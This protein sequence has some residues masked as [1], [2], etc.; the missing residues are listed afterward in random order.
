MLVLLSIFVTTSHA[1]A[2]TFK[3]IKLNPSSRWNSPTSEVLSRKWGPP[4][5]PR[6]FGSRIV[7]MHEAGSHSRR[8]YP[9]RIP[10]LFRPYSFDTVHHSK[11]VLHLLDFN[12]TS[13]CTDETSWW[14][15]TPIF[16]NGGDTLQRPH[17][18]H[19]PLLAGPLL[20]SL[21]RHHRRSKNSMYRHWVLPAPRAWHLPL[22]PRTCL[23][24][25]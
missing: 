22:P 16:E 19:L 25:L 7:H 10:S 14:S 4:L 5:M 9:S 24:R 12:I 23:L 21:P 15:T 6:V 18:R 2:C 8:T 1:I 20:P 13:S 3:S 17:H 11:S